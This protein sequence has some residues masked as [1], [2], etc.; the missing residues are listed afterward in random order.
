MSSFS[1][2]RRIS[3]ATSAFAIAAALAP[4]AAGAQTEEQQ[5]EAADIAEPIE[6]EQTAGAPGDDEIVVTGSR[7]P[8]ANFDTPQPAVV[9]GGEQ[10]EQ[11]G[12]TNLADALEELPA[13]GV[14][15][16]NPV[17]AA[18]Q[19][20]EFGSGQNFVNF[21]G[22]GDQRTLTIV[23]GRRFVSTNTASIFGPTGTNGS[24]VDFN[25]F[26]TLLV[27]RV[28][29]VAVGG[30]PIYG[31]DAIAGTINVITKRNFQGIQIDGQYGISER[32]DA[33][34]K[35]I[36]G[37]V[38]TNFDDGRGN[39]AISAEYNK[40][41]GLTYA[42]RPK[43]SLN[44]FFTSPGDDRP[45]AN[46][47]IEDR[48]IPS[49]AEFGI[50]QVSDL[51]FVLS[52]QRAAELGPAFGIPFP[53][54]VGVTDDLADPLS[55]NPLVFNEFGELVP[56]DFGEEMGDLITSNGGS[57][58]ILPGSLLAPTRRYIATALAQ[59]EVTDGIRL[60]GEGWYANSKGTQFTGQPEYNS[61]LFGLAGEPGGNLIISL[62]NPFLSDQAR[63]I[64]AANLANNPFTDDPDSFLLGRANVDIIS[65][66][67]SSTV[68]IYRFVGGFDGT[69]SAFGR[70]LTFELVGN[71][72]ESTTKGNGR[73]II[74][75]NLENALDAVLDGSG[76]IVCRPGA[77]NAPIETISST[78][79]PL[80]PFGGSVS[81]AARDYITT[82]TDP[83]AVNDQWVFTASVSGDLFDLPA[84]GVGFALGYEH[85]E[86]TAKVDPGT[87]Y[88]G[89]PDPDPTTDENG[90]GD[91]ANDRIPFGQSV[92][93]DP[94]SGGFDTDELFAELT[95]P[96]IGEDQAIPM[97]RSLELN[98]AFR[99]IDHSRAG[100]DPT[101][102]VGATWQPIRDITFRG[103]YTRSVRAPAVT[104]YFNPRSQVFTFANDPCDQRFLDT[105]A[106][107]ATR[108]ANCAS[109]GLS[110]DFTSAI[111]DRSFPG[112]FAGNPDL[113][114]ETAD[115]WTVGAVIRPRFIPGLTVAV[116]WVDIQVNDAVE[117]LTA[118][119]VL[120]AC[121]DSPDFP[122]VVSASGTNF[123]ELFTRNFAVDPADP[124]YGQITS[125]DTRF[126]NAAERNFE[127]LVAELAWH[128]DTP[129]LGAESS[130]DLG[131]N[132]LYNHKL[133]LQVS[134]ADLTTLKGSI[135]YSKHQATANL[136]YKNSG[137]AWQWQAQYFGKARNDPDA[138][139]SDY[140][141]PIVGDVVFFN[142]SI[143]WDLDDRFRFHVVVDNVFDKKPPFPVPAGGGTVTYFDGILGRYFKFGAGVK[144]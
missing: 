64:I 16:T 52:Q 96:L 110:P 23:N 41:E 30:A 59:Y 7:I 81:Q 25:L 127:G 34:N 114:N 132:Y 73:A 26:P 128:L 74:Q 8:R 61:Y 43:H 106:N 98:G 105:G 75:Q 111:V 109:E 118:T 142:T 17:G 91:P 18:N 3:V 72:G 62:D 49:I 115:S 32:G 143:V 126:E 84:G 140:D 11:R 125:I 90:D 97:I 63:G 94:V 58:F 47:Y 1:F 134:G 76:N 93:M 89:A 80:N 12:Y 82:V 129:F 123:C 144:F 107:P 5:Q 54:Q 40:Q 22:L 60:F 57:G 79:A 92:V 100:A 77:V 137:V 42:D 136:T 19:A 119:N 70:D 20:G 24:Q 31:S 45:F 14:P 15:G 85:R 130:L 71:Y 67:A 104:E 99:Y 95:I 120:N 116:D 117:G 9:L 55:G 28:E 66:V 102:T 108:Q 21:F 27:D 87:F 36:R 86:E 13:F 83:V 138:P 6:D 29:T 44:S 39:I 50:P 56:I 135:G 141:F 122:D 33:A 2:A 68:E 65:G 121:Y 10:I 48:R 78:C 139:D 69:F 4:T 37:A 124:R 112:T 46:V 88:R 131:V 51:F 53:L 38:G 103:N 35:R 101:Y 113:V 133:D